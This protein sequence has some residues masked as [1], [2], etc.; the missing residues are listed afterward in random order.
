MNTTNTQPTPETDALLADAA[1]ADLAL[2]ER[3][4]AFRKAAQELLSLQRRIAVYIQ[5]PAAW[6]DACDEHGGPDEAL[7]A[8]QVELEQARERLAR[9]KTGHIEVQKLRARLNDA[10]RTV[11]ARLFGLDME[12]TQREQTLAAQLKGIEAAREA[13]IA[14]MV[15]LGAEEATARSVARPNLGEI[16][17]LRVELAGIPELKA[18]NARLIASHV[19]QVKLACTEAPVGG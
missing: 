3:G 14:A 11:R 5:S 10:L 12:L 19:E 2:D 6:L 18:E 16:A 15:K 13:N 1:R 8:A 7:A 9:L 4:N 17:A